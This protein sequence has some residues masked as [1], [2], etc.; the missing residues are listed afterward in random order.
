MNLTDIILTKL[1]RSEPVIMKTIT[2][3][4]L[5]PLTKANGDLAQKF[6]NQYSNY[7][8]KADQLFN[9]ILAVCAVKN[10]LEILDISTDISKS[11][12][13]NP[14]MQLVENVADLYITDIGHLECR[15][16][17]SHQNICHIPAE[18]W[19]DRIGYVA[20]EISADHKQAK[21]LGF[22]DQVTEEEI[23][24]SRLEPISNLLANITAIEISKY[25]QNI[26]VYAI[27]AVAEP[28]AIVSQKIKDWVKKSLD[29]GWQTF[30]EFFGN[31]QLEYAGNFRGS[32][33]EN[34]SIQTMIDLIKN[35]QDDALRLHAVG[36]LGAIA[37]G[38]Q[39]A[40]DTLSEIIDTT[41]DDE[42]LWQCA[43]SLA[44]IDP[45][46]SKAVHRQ[47]KVINLGVDLNQQELT[48]IISL[49]PY[50]NEQIR[51]I[52]E[53]K[54]KNTQEV[55]PPNLKLILLSETNEILNETE[56]DDLMEMRLLVPLGTNLKVKISWNDQQ[57]LQENITI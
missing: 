34:E 55:L 52:L 47:V 24:I 35:A 17:K 54:P 14:V 40:I 11:Y 8:Q 53:L 20:V 50:N 38:N 2:K 28:L 10:Y 36:V 39:M 45:H 27:N 26:E 46:N 6:A 44:K 5:I 30:D 22:I 33:R 48:L 43:S 25:E 13:F 16:V 49:L 57:I 1:T 15:P 29:L 51:V 41:D 19:S 7:P 42:L 3:S 21:L 18:T 56:E 31:Y 9:N 37:Q 4:M 23:L 12:C 32:R